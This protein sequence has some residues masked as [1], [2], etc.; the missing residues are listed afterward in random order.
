M[1]EEI[2]VIDKNKM[3][4]LVERPINKEIIGVKRVYVKHYSDGSVQL[5]K[6]RLVPKDYSQQP[7]II[8]VKILL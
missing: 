2:N 7:S 8:I 5:N 4:Q 1:Q 6:A 3:W